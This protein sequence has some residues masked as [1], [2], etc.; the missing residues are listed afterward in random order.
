MAGGWVGHAAG[1]GQRA[2]IVLQYAPSLASVI[3]P[4]RQEGWMDKKKRPQKR[5]SGERIC[6]AIESQ[7]LSSS[8]IPSGRHGAVTREAVALSTATGKWRA[9]VGEPR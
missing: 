2:E 8:A 6:P 3:R 1:A 9:E 5:T 7:C 4:T